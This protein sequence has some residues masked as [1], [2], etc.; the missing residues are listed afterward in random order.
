M[1][2]FQQKPNFFQSLNKCTWLRVPSSAPQAGPSLTGHAF[3]P[4]MH[5]PICTQG[6]H[7]KQLKTQVKSE[8]TGVHKIL[9][10]S[11]SASLVRVR[12]QCL[13]VRAHFG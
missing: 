10:K 9:P 12:A 5:S 4:L 8:L 1:S 7:K 3:L 2:K 13:R 6:D 11:S